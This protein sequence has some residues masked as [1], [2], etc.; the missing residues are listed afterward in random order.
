MSAIYMEA[1][2]LP[3]R[4]I[5]LRLRIL[6]DNTLQ[7]LLGLVVMVTNV[8]DCEVQHLPHRQLAEQGVGQDKRV[9]VPVGKIIN[10]RAKRTHLA[11]QSIDDFLLSLDWDFPWNK[12]F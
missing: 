12:W 10:L 2:K 4:A 5:C 8:I 6:Q 7:I 1:K 3:L 9:K 11:V